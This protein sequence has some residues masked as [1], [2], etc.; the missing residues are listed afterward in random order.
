LDKS[1][2]VSAWNLTGAP[3]LDYSRINTLRFDPF[4]QLDL[5]IDK[6]YY[7]NKTTA[8]FYIDFQNFYNFQSE[9]QDIVVRDTDDQGNFILSDNGER[10]QLRTVK[11]TTG[12]FLPSIGII[13]EF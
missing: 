6:A 9:Q 8:K 10:Y 2:L 5:R 7:L 3:Y 4:H 1:S 12:T 11:N 13:I